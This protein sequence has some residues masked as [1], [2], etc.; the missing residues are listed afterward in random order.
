MKKSILLTFLI[1][2]VA[3][4][5]MSLTPARKPPTEDLILAGPITSW[6][7]CAEGS[8][9]SFFGSTSYIRSPAQRYRSQRYQIGIQVDIYRDGVFIGHAD[10]AGRVRLSDSGFPQV[11]DGYDLVSSVAA[12][13][14][15][16]VPVETIAVELH[17]T[18]SLLDRGQVLDSDYRTEFTTIGGGY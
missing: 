16:P 14:N 2:A 18:V 1:L 17:Y 8:S 13:W 10:G 3:L 6:G 11:P 5:T 12:I 9:C 15:E 4:T 7:W